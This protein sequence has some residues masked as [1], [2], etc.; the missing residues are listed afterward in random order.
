MDVAR[1]LA[2]LPQYLQRALARRHQSLVVAPLLDEREATGSSRGVR[3]DDDDILTRR[4]VTHAADD[5]LHAVHPHLQLHGSVAAD[6]MTCRR[7]ED[8]LHHDDVTLLESFKY[9]HEICKKLRKIFEN[10]EISS[11]ANSLKLENYFRKK[12]C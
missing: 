1:V 9:K 7:P 3:E 4:D 5:S 6:E 2:P 8:E 11:I 12:S 10:T